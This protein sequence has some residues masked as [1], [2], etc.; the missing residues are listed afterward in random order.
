MFLICA[1]EKFMCKYNANILPSSF[2]NFF[3][4]K[5]LQHTQH[6]GT[7]QQALENFHRK[8]VRSENYCGEKCCNTGNV[9]GPVTWVFISNKIH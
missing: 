7:S 2:D 1:L 6:H 9:L 8:H 3:F 5:T 4:I